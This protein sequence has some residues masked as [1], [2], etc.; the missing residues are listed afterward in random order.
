MH[1]ISSAEQFIK[2]NVFLLTSDNFSM[3]VN[4]FGFIKITLLDSISGKNVGTHYCII[5]VR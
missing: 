2:N 5:K 3:L 4:I 1:L